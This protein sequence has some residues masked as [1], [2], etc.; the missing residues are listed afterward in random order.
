MSLET[1]SSTELALLEQLAD[2]LLADQNAAELAA[3]SW[4]PQHRPG[5]EQTGL[6]PKE[7]TCG[8]PQVAAYRSKAQVIGYGGAAGGGK[9]D[10]LLGVAGD[11]TRHMRAL[12]FRRVFPSLAAL[13]ERS[14]EVYNTE[15]LNHQQDSFNE[16]L[17]RWRRSSGAIIELGSL[18][19]N[20]D[21][22]KYQGQPHDLLA[23]DEATEFP[24]A[25]IRFLMAWLRTTNK[26]VFCQMLLTFN[27]PMDEAGNWVVRFFAPWLDESH[28]HPAEDGE[29]RWFAM[30]DGKE[31]ECEDDTPVWDNTLQRLINPRSR[32]FFHAY[33][34]DNP[35]LAETDY[36]SQIDAL[37]EPLRSLLH[38]NF[39][40]GKVADPWQVIPTAWVE[41][42]MAR[43]RAIG[44]T[45]P[46]KDEQGKEQLPIAAAQ[47]PA[48]G[49]GDEC[50][51]ARLYLGGWYAPI[52]AQPGQLI[53]D[54]PKAAA[55][56]LPE[57]SG[58][59]PVG[60]DVIGIGSSVV[61]SAET[62]EGAVVI[63]INNAEATKLRDK[64]GKLKFVNVRACSYWLLREALDPEAEFPL[65]LPDDTLLKQDLCAVHYKV[66]VKGIQCEPKEAV[67]ERIGRS[68][69]RGDSVV[70]CNWT[71]VNSTPQIW[72]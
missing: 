61:D 30:V 31:V 46:P 13:I 35:A 1:A 39:K 20:S 4:R 15:N 66:T 19:Y 10:L 34:R 48:R 62:T 52:D 12:I 11:E 18:Q 23:F 9:S 70:M 50:C 36:S 72:L 56:L 58:G 54:G 49:G 16:G 32:T 3:R 2:Q 28:P 27:P 59:V 21:L 8:C 6:A 24:E 14:R 42:A 64:L 60:I 53:D 41:A 17:H 68:P 29:I 65:A 44:R 25:F 33:L 51:T 43:W 67:R 37:P 38:G 40:A 22:K 55:L 26:A 5:C 69:D 63:R 57:L 7:T 47:D 71:L 45:T